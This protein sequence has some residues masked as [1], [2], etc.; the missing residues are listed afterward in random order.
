MNSIGLKLI[1]DMGCIC[2]KETIVING[3][4]Y[5]VLERIA[6]GD[7]LQFQETQNLAL[8]YAN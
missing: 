7:F 8:F 1:L 4:K 2:S 5:K 6:E 3:S